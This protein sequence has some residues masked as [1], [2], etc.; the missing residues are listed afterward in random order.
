M[1]SRAARDPTAITPEVSEAFFSAT[2]GVFD[3]AT[4]GAIMSQLR[5]VL[6]VSKVVLGILARQPWGE[7]RDATLVDLV[8]RCGPDSIRDLIAEAYDKQSSQR[9]LFYHIYRGAPP[10]CAPPD[11]AREGRAKALATE[12]ERSCYAEAVRLCMTEANEHIERR[13]TSVQFV[14]LYS[15]RC[16]TISQ[17]LTAS[18][19]LMKKVLGGVVDAG[20]LGRM[21]SR[22]LQPEVFL[23]EERNVSMRVNKTVSKRSETL[24]KCPN[25]GAKECDVEEVQMCSADE[26]AH[27]MCTC[28]KCGSRFMGHD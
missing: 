5:T 25:C 27:N 6:E 10:D 14:E 9:A 11:C 22:E 21:T 18:P 8:G 17:A 2:E 13:W 15:M 24:Y 23:A 7:W 20:A 12:T 28:H 16:S 3:R 26:P 19:V 1:A 4:A